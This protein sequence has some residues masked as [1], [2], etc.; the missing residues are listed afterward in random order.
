MNKSIQIQCPQEI[1]LGLHLDAEQF[2][3][4]VAEAAALSLFR[5]GKLSSG[6]AARWLGMPRAHFLLKAMREGNAS[7]LEDNE[8][9]FNRETSLL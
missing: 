7:L 1:L 5:E 9:D 2:S 6:M 8:D 4:L 3:S